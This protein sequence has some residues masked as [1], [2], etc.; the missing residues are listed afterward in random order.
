MP[1]EKMQPFC[2]CSR[3][4]NWTGKGLIKTYMVKSSSGYCSIQSWT[5][6]RKWND[7]QWAL[8]S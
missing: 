3:V 5:N 1:A 2:P 4:L 6:T 8:M 7:R